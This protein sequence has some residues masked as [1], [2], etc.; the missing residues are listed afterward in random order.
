VP[1]LV[2]LVVVEKLGIGALCPTPRGFIL[3]AGKDAHGDR[4]TGPESLVDIASATVSRAGH[5]VAAIR[6][7]RSTSAAS[8]VATVA[9]FVAEAAVSARRT[10]VDA[11]RSTTN[12]TATIAAVSVM[13]WGCR[14]NGFMLISSIA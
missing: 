12:A 1:A 4:V 5:S 8:A 3:L 9:I 11:R 14:S 2:D 6:V 10:D 7:R 13:G